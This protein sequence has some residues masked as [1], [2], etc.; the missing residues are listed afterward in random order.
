MKIQGLGEFRLRIGHRVHDTH[1]PFSIAAL[2]SLSDICSSL[3]RAWAVVIGCL[4]NLIR[5]TPVAV[6]ML[7]IVYVQALHYHDLPQFHA[8]R[9]NDRCVSGR[10]RRKEEDAAGSPDPMSVGG[11]DEELARAAHQWWIETAK[12]AR[13][14]LT[15]FD[16]AAPL[17]ERIAWA[18]QAGLEIAA[19]L[20][21]FSSKLQHST[22]AQVQH[23]VEYAAFHKMYTPPEY[24]SVDE[25]EKGR[26]VRRDG[27]ERT[28]AILRNRWVQTLLVFKVSR[29]LRVGYKGFAFVNE[30]VVEQ[31]LR[32][33]STSQGIDTR[34]AKTWKALMYL[35]GMMDEMLLDTIADHCRAGLKTL[36][37]QGYTTG[38]IPVGYRRVEVPGAPLTNRKLPRTMPQIDPEVA[39]LIKMH[40]EWIRDGMTIKEGWRRWLAAGG[41]CDP[42]STLKH[43]SCQAYRRL[44]SNSRFL[45][46]WA[47]GRKRN[48]WLSK[49]D[50]NGQID[51]PEAEVAIYR[52]EELRI[53]DDELF[54]AVQ[55]RLAEFKLGPRGPHKQKK[56]IHLW[57]LTTEF[58]YCA[59]CKVRFYQTGAH[60]KGMQCKRGDLCPCKSAVRRKEAVQAICNKLAELIQRDADFIRQIVC[61]SREIDAQGDD[62]SQTDINSRKSKIQTLTNKI[63]DLEELSGQGSEEDRRRRKAMINAVTS[64]RATLQLELTRL[65]RT[66]AGGAKAITPEQITQILHDFTSLLEN[67]ANGKLGEDVVY[68][69][70]RIF[71]Q[72]TGGRIWVHVERRPGR[73]QTNVRGIFTPQLLKATKT[74]TEDHDVVDNQPHEEEMVW[75]REPP[76]L[77]AIAE[78]VHQ[79]MDIE[80]LSYREAAKV[81]QKNDPRINSGNVWYSYRRWYQMQGLPVPEQTYNNGR[82]RKSR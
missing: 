21:R 82:C 60:G 13:I 5:R 55:A 52:C 29:L 24:I 38:A 50:Y 62:Q 18:S 79:L 26:R 64:E 10:P 28:K 58:Y 35:H 2:E 77:D 67:A 65:E 16:P 11:A 3:S 9:L 43:M 68:K 72:L 59:N 23:A 36:F 47:F 56:E 46:R 4:V 44:L 27:L 76:R 66:L 69:A 81:L 14:D 41:P 33:V 70:F 75:L 25:A 48:R 57:D 32:A 19:A 63:N 78:R 42:R 20:S 51:G 71:R 15:G 31:G 61:R 37:Q 7:A 17:A 54:F 74:A 12:K 6:G 73:K 39:K 80:G 22:Q 8:P 45:G 1:V 49:L 34:D 40:F 53:L 30:E